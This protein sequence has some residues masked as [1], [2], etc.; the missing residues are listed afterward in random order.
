M[1]I[2]NIQEDYDN[3][4]SQ[5]NGSQRQ[6]ADVSARQHQ[7]ENSK[8]DQQIVERQDDQSG[9]HEGSGD[10]QGLASS[11][12]IMKQY[13]CKKYQTDDFIEFEEENISSLKVLNDKIESGQNQE[14][15]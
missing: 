6:N 15:E 1:G 2:H 4:G 12:P 11:A 9:R 14:N 7:A 13:Y 10:A 5:Y 3:E 8:D